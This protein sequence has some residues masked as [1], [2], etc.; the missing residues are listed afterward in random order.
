MVAFRA[1]KR[2]FLRINSY[3]YSHSL[4]CEVSMVFIC[5]KVLEEE[6]IKTRETYWLLIQ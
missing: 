2:P 5:L 6:I 4:R 3:L 1:L